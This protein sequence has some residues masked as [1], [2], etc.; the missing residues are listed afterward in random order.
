[1]STDIKFFFKPI[2]KKSGELIPLL[3]SFSIRG[4]RRW[5]DRYRA[6]ANETRLKKKRIQSNSCFQFQRKSTTP[7]IRLLKDHAHYSYNQI[8]LIIQY[9]WLAVN[10]TVSHFPWDRGV[11]WSLRSLEIYLEICCAIHVY[12]ITCYMFVSPQPSARSRPRSTVGLP[13]AAV[14][15]SFTRLSV[16]LCVL[17]SRSAIIYL[18]NNCC[19]INWDEIY[20]LA[21]SEERGN[22]DEAS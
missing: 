7:F 17:S 16:C 21:K 10:P 9:D 15:P 6:Q 18:V 13:A 5:S 12:A 20:P 1:M 2:F 11:S 14:G 19:L 8:L 22:I 4:R 3:E